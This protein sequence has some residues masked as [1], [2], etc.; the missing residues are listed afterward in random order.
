MLSLI[1]SIRVFEGDI[2]IYSFVLGVSS[3]LVWLLGRR[4]ALCLDTKQGDR[5]ILHGRDNLLQRMYIILDRM[6]DGCPLEDAL[7]GLENLQ[8]LE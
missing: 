1:A 7:I 2:Q 3:L 5:H 4:P 6:S 8:T